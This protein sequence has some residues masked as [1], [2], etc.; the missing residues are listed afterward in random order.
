[1]SHIS[2]YYTPPSHYSNSKQL[3]FKQQAVI[4]ERLP[5]ISH[6]VYEFAEQSLLELYL[7]KEAEVE[8]LAHPFDVEPEEQREMS[9]NVSA[10]TSTYSYRNTY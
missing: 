9:V 3:L 6:I 2:H 8:Y 7:M 5:E 10:M 1:M 4:I